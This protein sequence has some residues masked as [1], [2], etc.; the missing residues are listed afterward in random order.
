MARS[1]NGRKIIARANA[2]FACRKTLLYQ[3][4]Y[5]NGNCRMNDIADFFVKIGVTGPA[6]VFASGLGYMIWRTLGRQDRDIE[7]NVTLATALSVLSQ[8]VT[9]NKESLAEM[10]QLL[11]TVEKAIA[12]V[13]SRGDQ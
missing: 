12:R 1:T 10:K 9:A 11:I 7:T 6:A 4:G 5:Y 2:I 13:E 3:Q 8:A